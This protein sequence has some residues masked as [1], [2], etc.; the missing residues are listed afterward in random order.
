[1]R[2]TVNLEPDLYAL[3][4]SLAKAEDCSI[5]AAVNRLL[6]RSLPNGKELSGRR[7]RRPSKRSG[8]AISR[9]R[10]PITADTVRQLEA[11]DDEA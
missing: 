10:T 4:K 2:L 9:G 5:S 3:A 11:E 8:F 6:R 7:M 1:M